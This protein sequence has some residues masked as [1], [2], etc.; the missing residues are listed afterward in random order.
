M[1]LGADVNSSLSTPHYTRFP[2]SHRRQCKYLNN[3]K[4]LLTNKKLINK[5]TTNNKSKLHS[6]L[7]AQA[8]NDLHI[9]SRYTII[10]EV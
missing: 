10:R 7:A 5:S 6:R 2:F 8:G 1:L 4:S 9:V 3:S